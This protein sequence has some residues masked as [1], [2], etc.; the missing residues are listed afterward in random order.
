MDEKSIATASRRAFVKGATL[1]AGV[2][3][4]LTLTGADK[5]FAQGKL[6]EETD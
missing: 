4:V 5:A 1:L 2:A 6:T 3:V